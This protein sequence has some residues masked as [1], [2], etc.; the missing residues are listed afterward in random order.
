MAR[1]S[2]GHLFLLDAANGRI[3]T[4]VEGDT[5]RMTGTRAIEISGY[6]LCSAADKLF[7]S[8]FQ[9]N[10]LVHQFAMGATDARIAAS[11]GEPR[12]QGPLGLNPMIQERMGNNPIAC[13][14][15]EPVIMLASRDLGIVEIIRT[16]AQDQHAVE[17]P[18]FE[19]MMIESGDGSLTF[20]VPE[21]GHYDMLVD[22]QPAAGGAVA[23]VHRVKGTKD[24][25]V[26]YR[27]YFIALT[28]AV[29]LL[30]RSAWQQVGAGR[31]LTYC[32]AEN[33]FPEVAIFRGTSCP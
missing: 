31:G 20:G 2:S 17:L 33:P 13:V 14:P 15:D 28:G 9:Q 19:R 21:S 8:S 5:L 26:E 3:T 24:N 7:V 22:I 1:D 12:I 16:D 4:Y 10:G 29:R 32:A 18:G 30:G 27:R 25:S 6:G 23:I 11:F